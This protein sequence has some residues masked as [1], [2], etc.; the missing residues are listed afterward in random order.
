MNIGE[1]CKLIDSAGPNSILI[2]DFNF[3]CI[4]GTYETPSRKSGPFFD[5]T[6]DMEQ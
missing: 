6:K 4:K 3:S 5:S 2:G 1:L